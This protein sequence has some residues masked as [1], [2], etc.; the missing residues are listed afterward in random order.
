[1]ANHAD[2]ISMSL[3]TIVDLSTS[4]GAGLKAAV[5]RVTY[6]ASQSGLVLVAAAGNDG[7]DLSNPRFVEL[8]AQARNVLAIVASTNPACAQ[9]TDPSATC[10]AGPV[11]LAYYSNHGAPLQ[12]LAAPGGS[13][14]P[15]QDF[16]VSGWVRGACSSGKPSTTTGVPSDPAHS[17]GCFNLGHTP[18]VQAMG[19]SAAAPLAAGVAALL[20]SAHPTWTSAAIISAM[21]NSA[22]HPPALPVGQID[23][24]AA[25]AIP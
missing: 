23:A 24:A 10:M 4:E 25:L 2:V 17:F 1:M 18:Y 21:R 8:P 6:A 16:A 7:W 20:R 5:D 9:N 22:S 11:G 19:S 15:G 3:G 13:Y 12:A 14:P